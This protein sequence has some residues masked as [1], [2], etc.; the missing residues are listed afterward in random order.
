MEEIALANGG[1]VTI[2]AFFVF[3]SSHWA[4]EKLIG[5]PLKTL[6]RYIVGTGLIGALFTAWCFLQPG[7]ILAWW[8]AV[9]FWAIAV[10]SGLGTIMGH[11]LDKTSG[12]STVVRMHRDE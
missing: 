11:Y 9:S 6:E 1:V 8:A 4:S 3:M 5:R 7:P 12:D 10:G 2:L